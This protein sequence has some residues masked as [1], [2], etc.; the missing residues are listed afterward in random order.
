MKFNIDLGEIITKS[1]KITWKFKILWIF[2]ILSGCVASNRG[3]FNFNNSG[4]GGGGN[5][6]NGNEQLP[7]FLRQFQNMRFEQ[8]VR[9]FLNQYFGIIIAVMLVLCVLWL[10]F[11]LLKHFLGLMG[12]AGLIK[13]AGKAD[14]GAESMTFGELLTESLP[15]IWRMFWLTLI[16]ELPSFILVVILL[17]GIGMGAYTAIT[18]DVSQGG[19]I[20]MIAGLV[21]TFV[22]LVCCLSLV[23]LVVGLIVEQSYNAIVLED[24]SLLESLGRGWEVFSKNWFSV[25][26][27]GLV[28]WVM[29]LA[30]GI[31][32]FIVSLTI[33]IPLI[34]VVI[35]TVSSNASLTTEAGKGA[36]VALILTLC[37]TALI[38]VPISL[39]LGGIQ[40]TYFQSMWTLTFRRLT[41]L[42]QPR[43]P[44][45][46]E[47]IEPQ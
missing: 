45:R 7:D 34:V 30:I 16:I 6:N 1:W 27:V 41:A 38:L 35:L 21:G 19:L 2:G 36:L 28:Q 25:V 37:C 13:G 39:L 47:V 14:A 46:V 15:Y 18:G 10:F 11:Y 43:L 44:E 33:A 3:N 20:A 12:K 24:R 22:L 4:G 29:A 42:V 31:V 5:G 23:M 32:E 17:A 8:A 26:V 40:N 9:E